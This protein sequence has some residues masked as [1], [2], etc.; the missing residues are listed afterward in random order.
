MYDQFPRR[1]FELKMSK[2][3]IVD[4]NSVS[5]PR[6]II[7]LDEERSSE[8]SLVPVDRIAMHDIVHSSACLRQIDLHRRILEK[9]PTVAFGFADLS[10]RKAKSPCIVGY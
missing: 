9:T 10:T 3:G 5:H 8:A 7:S 2:L 4:V 1:L 6:S